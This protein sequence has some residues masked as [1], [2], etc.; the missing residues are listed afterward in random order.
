MSHEK[1]EQKIKDNDPAT[2]LNTLRKNIANDSIDSINEHTISTILNN[3][4]KTD[5]NGLQDENLVKL[6][7]FC[8][9]VAISF[10]K[11]NSSILALRPLLYLKRY[12]SEKYSYIKSLLTDYELT[13]IDRNDP[14]TYLCL[15]YLDIKIA[16]YPLS[17]LVSCIKDLDTNLVMMALHDFSLSELITIRDHLNTLSDRTDASIDTSTLITHHINNSNFDLAS[18]NFSKEVKKPR[19]ALCLSGQMRG[20]VDAFKSWQHSKL[21]KNY[22]VDIY[23]ST[24]E[25]IGRKFPSLQ[26]AHRTFDEPFL[27]EYISMLNSSSMSLL[28]EKYTNFFTYLTQSDYVNLDE[29]HKTYSHRLKNI[30]CISEE[31]LPFE[32]E[33]NQMRMFYQIQEC[34]NLVEDEYDI[35]IRC[36]PDKPIQNDSQIDWDRIFSVAMENDIIF[37]D[38]ST[39]IH[40]Y[41]G[42]GMGDQFAL[43]NRQTMEKYCNSFSSLQHDKCLARRVYPPFYPHNSLAANLAEPEI[44]V[45]TIPGLMFW[46]LR[47]PVKFSN[48]DILSRIMMD[49]NSRPE[50]KFDSILT[51]ALTR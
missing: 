22:S 49:V 14:H 30:K 36:R 17:N 2:L 34:F 26:H 5:I 27:N 13:V 44:I 25:K 46:S 51:T 11:T 21:L 32:L 42:Y 19:V 41:A 6:L 9:N 12:N 45:T 29:I 7:K 47:D 43:G 8:I 10:N 16:D 35:V 24:W 3:I 18:S 1:T 20:Y 48:N 15:R 39:F 38:V 50:F 23:I 4:V 28:E 37:S 33:N 31:T 40:P